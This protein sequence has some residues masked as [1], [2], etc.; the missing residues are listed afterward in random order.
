MQII[1]SELLG[2]VQILKLQRRKNFGYGLKCV[3]NFLD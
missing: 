3:L 2:L 1:V